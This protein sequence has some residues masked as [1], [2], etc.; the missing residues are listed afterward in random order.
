MP[1]T[2]L[3]LKVDHPVQVILLHSDQ[4][5][6]EVME[7]VT[8]SCKTIDRFLKK[9]DRFFCLYRDMY[10]QKKLSHDRTEIQFLDERFRL[11]LIFPSSFRHPHDYICPTVCCANKLS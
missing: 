3:K 11:R 10:K 6:R 4:L 9:Q 7:K 1:N 8:A 5:G 2:P